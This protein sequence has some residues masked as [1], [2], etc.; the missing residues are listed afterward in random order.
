VEGGVLVAGLPKAI[1]VVSTRKDSITSR[2]VVSVDELG[3]VVASWKEEEREKDDRD[4][5]KESRWNCWKQTVMNKSESTAHAL[6]RHFPNCAFSAKLVQCIK[7]SI[8]SSSTR[9]V[10]KEQPDRPKADEP[11]WRQ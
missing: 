10:K 9:T 1:N 7:E 4:W 5:E 8:V 2:F 3:L 6:D 11:N